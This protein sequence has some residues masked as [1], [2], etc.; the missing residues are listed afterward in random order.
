[1]ET[2]TPCNRGACSYAECDDDGVCQ[3]TDPFVCDACS[4]CDPGTGCIG[5]PL[6][7]GAGE[8]QCVPPVDNRSI[9]TAKTKNPDSG[10]SVVWKWGK[11][12]AV[13]PADFG[14]PTADTDYRMCVFA[15]D[16][17]SFTR[18]I[19]AVDLPAGAS[20]TATSKGFKYKSP[21]AIAQLTAGSED[22]KSRIK[23]KARG[24]AAGLPDSLTDYRQFSANGSSRSSTDDVPSLW[25][26][27][28]VEVELRA[29]NGECWGVRLEDEVKNTPA[30]LKAKP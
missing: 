23:L 9:L 17:L 7:I 4:I 22:G 20:W 11:G 15:D 3:L 19:S 14:D 18:S 29:S 5:A 27:A 28:P 16:P 6:G 2:G 30:N 26:G 1:M 13:D 12:P 24:A 25:I 10:D 21:D 8:G